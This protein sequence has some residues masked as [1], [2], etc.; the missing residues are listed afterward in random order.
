MTRIPAPT[1]HRCVFSF[2]AIAVLFAAA[3]F[4]TCSGAVLKIMPLGDSITAGYYT[5]C[6]YR[7]TLQSLL[8]A[9]GYSYDFV[10]RSTDNSGG[11]A[12]PEHEGYAGANI[13]SIT[14]RGTSAMPLFHPDIVLLCAGTNDMRGHSD[15]SDPDYYAAAA[16]RLNNLLSALVAYPET[17]V[18]VGNLMYF[19]GDLYAYEQARADSFNAQLAAIIATRRAQGQKVFLA[20]LHGGLT[21]AETFDG[22]HPNDAGYADMAHVWFHGIEQATAAPEPATVAMLGIAIVGV[23]VYGCRSKGK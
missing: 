6:G 20:D 10:G 18:L 4:P 11:M 1:L 16:D 17:T 2:A 14:D 22:L 19:S 15:P 13:R 23:L 8:T 3:P 21:A 7:S 12:D 9:A 5:N